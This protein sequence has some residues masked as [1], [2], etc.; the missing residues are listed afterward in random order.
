MKIL[1]DDMPLF[2]DCPFYDGYA[3][4]LDRHKCEYMNLSSAERCMQKECK[5]LKEESTNASDTNKERL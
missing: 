2:Q 1:V 3:C 4:I 5:W